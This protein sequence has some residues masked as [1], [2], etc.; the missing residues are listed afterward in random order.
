MIVGVR[1][2]A[3]LFRR[4]DTKVL[5]VTAGVMLLGG[6]VFYMLDEDWS[7]VDSFYF[8]VTTL[9]TTGF[10]DLH[11]T[12][13]ESKLFTCF[14]LLGGVGVFVALLTAIAQEALSVRSKQL[15]GER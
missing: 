2:S 1:A 4:R 11:P 5:L 9:T 10:G 14:Y 6:S 12:T 7:F 3:R 8:A 15:D 13:T